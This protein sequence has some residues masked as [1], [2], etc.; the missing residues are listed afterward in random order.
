MH[1]AKL[2]KIWRNNFFQIIGYY[3]RFIR[4][5]KNMVNHIKHPPEISLNEFQIDIINDLS[6]FSNPLLRPYDDLNNW[7]MER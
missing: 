4:I 3:G 6:Y 2:P 5:L 1:Q 7:N